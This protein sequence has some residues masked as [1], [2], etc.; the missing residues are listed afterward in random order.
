MEQYT[1]MKTCRAG[2]GVKG[3]PIDG[4][5]ENAEMREKQTKRE[6]KRRMIEINPKHTVSSSHGCPQSDCSL[7]VIV[8]EFIQQDPASGLPDEHRGD[9][10][11]EADVL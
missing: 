11:L 1:E 3:T 4:E 8:G 7:L 5:G 6:T 10:D 9:G 2:R